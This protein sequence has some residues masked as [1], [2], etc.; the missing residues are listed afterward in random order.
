MTTKKIV[1]WT[2]GGIVALILLALVAGFVLLNH[3]QRFRA[4][5][6]QR[7]EQSVYES[8]GARVTARD[9]K[10]ALSGLQLDIY[11]IAVHGK[12]SSSQRPLL[13]ADHLGVAIEIDSVLGGKWHLQSMMA[14][15]PVANV[16]VNKGGETNL[17]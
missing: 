4:Y 11:G 1:L 17:P 8:T 14:D 10:V 7:V 5:L 15:R 9:F 3:S 2:A 16:A 6:L 12:E 13:T